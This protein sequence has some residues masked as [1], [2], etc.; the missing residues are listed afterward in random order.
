MLILQQVC[1]GIGFLES[2]LWEHMFN[3]AAK[4]IKFQRNM[5]WLYLHVISVYLQNTMNDEQDDSN[6]LL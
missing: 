6:K 1:D 4:L 3:Y 5:F 2:V